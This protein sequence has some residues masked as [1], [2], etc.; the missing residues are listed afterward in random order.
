MVSIK[1]IGGLSNQMFQSAFIYS[2]SKK[3]GLDYVVPKTVIAPHIKGKGA[4]IFPGINY[5]ENIPILPII[6]EEHYHYVE[7]TK[8]DN[9]CF[10]GYFQSYKYYDEYREDILKA[11]GLD[12]INTEENVCA[13]HVRRGDYLLLPTKH[14]TVEPVY[15]TKAIM[16]MTEN[17]YNKFRVFSDDMPYCKNFFGNKILFGDLEFEFSED[18]TEMEDLRGIVSCESQICSNST[19][20]Y[21]GAYSNP[22]P[23]KKI[24][25]PSIW[26]G[27]DISKNLKDLYLPGSIII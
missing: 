26:F 4:Y 1:L 16:Y 13:I 18:K 24:V 19:Y 3:H 17:G 9:V 20:S 23:D 14:P 8:M 21:W 5:S 7:F 10:D 12:D 2:F 6:K 25:M 22:N 27:P 11:F 15:L